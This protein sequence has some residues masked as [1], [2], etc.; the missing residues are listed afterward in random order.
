MNEVAV[1]L[2][3]ELKTQRSKDV[4]SVQFLPKSKQ[5][6]CKC[7]KDYSKNYVERQRS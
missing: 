6:F 3:M 5:N 1:E 7:G 4:S 2:F